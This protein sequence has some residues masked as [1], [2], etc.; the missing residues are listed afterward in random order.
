[1]D[2]V[3]LALA[4]KQAISSSNAYTDGKLEGLEL[5]FNYK[6]SV[7]SVEDLPVSGNEKGDEYTI[8]DGSGSYAWNGTSWDPAGA[9]G[10]QGR[11][12]EQGEQGPAG[13]DGAIHYT[14]GTDIEITEDHVINNTKIV[15]GNSTD[16]TTAKLTKLKIDGI[17]YALQGGG[18]SVFANYSAMVTEFNSKAKADLELGWNVYIRTLDVPDLWVS[19]NDEETSVPYTYTT[20]AQFITDL[21]T[22]AASGLQIGYYRVNQLES[23]KVSVPV[24]D[25]KVNGASV[26][27]G[28]VANITRMAEQSFTCE[29]ADGTTKTLKLYSEL[30]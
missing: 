19:K 23:E 26:L 22:A 1:M 11:Q 3:T 4:K 24:Q 30:V 29:M 18:A 15:E 17:N 8:A 13:R 16:A 5:G 12:G 14:A 20:D 2:I 25:V 28:G 27:N 7:A 10:P 9:Q 21:K 6:G